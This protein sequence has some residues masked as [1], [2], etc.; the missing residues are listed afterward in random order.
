[1][2]ADRTVTFV[3][4]KPGLLQGDGA[5]LAGEVSVADIGLPPAAP[6]ISVIEDGDVADP[7]PRP[8]ARAEQMVGARCWWW[9]DRRG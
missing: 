4:L 2:A 3:A 1:M 8:P 5:R 9:P 6:G 7:L